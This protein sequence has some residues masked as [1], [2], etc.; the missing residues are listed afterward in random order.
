VATVSDKPKDEEGMD[1]VYQAQ[2]YRSLDE[3]KLLEQLAGDLAD[4]ERDIAAAETDADT[5]KTKA[6]QAVQQ[7]DNQAGTP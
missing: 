1:L 3:K 6:A 4:I 2:S 7:A 5:A